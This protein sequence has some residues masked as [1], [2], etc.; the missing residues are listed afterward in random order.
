MILNRKILIAVT[1]VALL[2]QLTIPFFAFYPAG[3]NAFSQKQQIDSI[4]GDKVFICTAEGFR[5]I[6]SAELMELNNTPSTPHDQQIE[7][8]LCFLHAKTA[9]TKPHAAL[10][11]IALLLPSP[12]QRE[13]PWFN[14]L[15]SYTPRLD[16][17]PSPT[18][19]PPLFS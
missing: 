3:A 17:T 7:C 11:A 18:R 8:A 6:S 2:F 16:Q 4:F 13:T 1:L 14:A 15:P 10:N 9:A 12:T 5:W 19:A